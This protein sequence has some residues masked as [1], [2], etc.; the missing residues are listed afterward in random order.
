[1]RSPDG[2]HGTVTGY[3]YGCRDECCRGAMAKYQAERRALLR[4]RKIPKK[5]HGTLNG[6][7]TYSCRCGACATAKSEYYLQRRNLLRGRDID[8]FMPHDGR[9]AGAHDLDSD[10]RSQRRQN[11]SS[12]SPKSAQHGSSVRDE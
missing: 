2:Y 10:T 8:W 9:S 4:T 3:T 5:V 6:Y 11:N 1:V 12:K 7:V